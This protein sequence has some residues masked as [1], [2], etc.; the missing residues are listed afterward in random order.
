MNK[1]DIVIIELNEN[2]DNINGV[3][4]NI[5]YNKTQEKIVQPNTKGFLIFN[6]KKIPKLIEKQQYKAKIVRC[7]EETT[8]GIGIENNKKYYDLILV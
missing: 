5:V 1:N 4:V 2:L 3:I 6:N 7:S 8:S